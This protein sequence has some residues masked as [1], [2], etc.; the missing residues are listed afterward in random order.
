M[1]SSCQRVG[2]SESIVS[3]LPPSAPPAA[4]VNSTCR[5]AS[6]VTFSLMKQR[7]HWR[8]RPSLLL[9]SPLLTHASFSLEI[10]C[11][12]TSE[13]FY[14]GHILSRGRQPPHGELQPLCFFAAHGQEEQDKNS[15]TF[16]NDAEVSEVVERVE[17]IYRKWPAAWGEHGE[18]SIGVVT[19]Y[20]DQVFRMRIAL[21]K[22]RLH[23]VSVERVLN[24]QGKQFRVVLLSTVR[25]W[26]S[27]HTRAQ[28]K[29]DGETESE[30][31]LGFL[32][33][34]K[35]LNTAV[36]RAQSLLAV[37][38]DPIALCSSGRCR[39]VWEH[40]LAAC[41]LR[42][43]LYGTS[44]ERVRSELRGLELKT[45]VLNPLAPE[46]V[47]RA[48]RQPQPATQAHLLQPFAWSHRYPLLRPRCAV[49]GSPSQ[50]KNCAQKT[51]QQGA[52]E[53]LED[54]IRP[55][56]NLNPLFSRKL[57]EP[58]IYPPQ[59][60]VPG[61]PLLHAD[62]QA[63]YAPPNYPCN[64]LI[65][66]PCP[67]VGW[68][69]PVGL[70]SQVFS[71]QAAALAYQLTLLQTSQRNAQLQS[72][73]SHVPPQQQAATR[74]SP[75]LPR[76]RA[77]GQQPEEIEDSAVVGEGTNSLP[78]YAEAE[79][80]YLTS[81]LSTCGK[82]EDEVADERTSHPVITAQPGLAH[83]IAVQN[84][85]QQIP[86]P[87]AIPGLP[88]SFVGPASGL[89][90]PDTGLYQAQPTTWPQLLTTHSKEPPIGREAWEVEAHRQ[91]AS[92]NAWPRS[93]Q[94][95]IRPQPDKPGLVAFP[96]SHNEMATSLAHRFI[97]FRSRPTHRNMVPGDQK[98]FLLRPHLLPFVQTHH[99]DLGA[100]ASTPAGSTSHDAS[101]MFQ[102]IIPDMPSFD[103][104]TFSAFPAGFPTLVQPQCRRAAMHCNLPTQPLVPDGQAKPSLLSAVGQAPV[105]GPP[106]I[107][108]ESPVSSE[109]GTAA[110]YRL[111]TSVPFRPSGGH[112]RGPWG[113]GV[114]PV[115]PNDG[116]QQIP[117]EHAGWPVHNTDMGCYPVSNAFR[118]R[119]QHLGSSSQTFH[120]HNPVATNVYPSTSSQYQ[121]PAQCSP[122]QPLR[123]PAVN[124]ASLA[125]G[126]A[127]PTTVQEHTGNLF[128]STD[129]DSWPLLARKSI[130]G[131]VP[132]H[133]LS[134]PLRH[135]VNTHHQLPGPAHPPQ[136]QGWQQ[137]L[138]IPQLWEHLKADESGPGRP[139]YK[140]G[141]TQQPTQPY[142][143]FDPCPEPLSSAVA[144]VVNQSPGRLHSTGHITSTSN[145]GAVSS[146]LHTC[147][148]SPPST[149]TTATLHSPWRSHGWDGEDLCQCCAHA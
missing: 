103:D 106:A 46:F 48:L 8:Q 45:Y 133:N 10:T 32:S 100:S 104:R 113:A 124:Q 7:R 96:P 109:A 18:C 77:S 82:L 84:S 135:D 16:Y 63:P 125:V 12:F 40:F 90:M 93:F 17:E 14:D 120:F 78:S 34:P 99:D 6:S 41:E 87:R 146:S 15:I 23:D 132:S 149:S 51:N 56:D 47:P 143:P 139:L 65:P 92:A 1:H 136:T 13:M 42:G 76:Y 105:R 115:R 64:V 49:I 130:S 70:D 85:G 145:P 38:G 86:L 43:S 30:L 54:F 83:N 137:S 117:L 142:R 94:G 80:P 79:M 59:S 116:T 75:I 141:L 37:V 39:K 127:S 126:G 148:S 24:V 19:P 35:L 134:Q 122:A 129:L 111:F 57:P 44:L 101:L 91:L 118:F 9:C 29:E 144:A 2:M 138:G 3:S 50:T 61:S 31:E 66:L 114:I 33:D 67:Q 110:P 68:H 98:S 4:F 119:G 72:Q 26:R 121:T 71:Q 28:R 5:Q 97:A 95:T 36:T 20:A 52:V 53:G 69:G 22:K 88:A 140:R 62:R 81:L 27:Y 60:L 107:S 73:R 131:R 102:P 21:R 55:G 123:Y 108:R 74:E 128:S 58:G 25:T 112:D 11:S 147:S 89:H